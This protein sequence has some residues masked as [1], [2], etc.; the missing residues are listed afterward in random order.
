MT[1]VINESNHKVSGYR[2]AGCRIFY[3]YAECYYAGRRIFIVVL[4]VIMLGITFYHYAQCHY[5]KCRYAECYYAGHRIF[6]VVPNVIML[7]I[8]FLSLC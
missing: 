6:I 2:Y 5:T 3:R 8:A 4:N 7:G 1:L